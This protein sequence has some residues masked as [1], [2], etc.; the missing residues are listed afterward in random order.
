LNMRGP[1]SLMRFPTAIMTAQERIRENKPK[2]LLHL[3]I[4][5]Y[6]FMATNKSDHIYALLGIAC[7]SG[8]GDLGIVADYKE[9]TTKV[10][11]QVAEAIIKS[12]TNLELLTAVQ[13]NSAAT[14]GQVEESVP[15]LPSWVPNWSISPGTEILARAIPENQFSATKSSTCKA[16]V[17]GNELILSGLIFDEI[18]AVSDIFSPKDSLGVTD[19]FPQVHLRQIGSIA[20][21]GHKL[22]KFF[23]KQQKYVNGEDMGRAANMTRNAGLAG[24][25]A[26]GPINLYGHLFRCS[27]PIYSFLRAIGAPSLF[28]VVGLF[29][30]L[31][32]PFFFGSRS[33]EWRSTTQDRGVW[34]SRRFIRSTRG[35]IGL[36]STNV[37]LGDK[38]ALLEGGAVPFIVRIKE[39]AAVRDHT[40]AELIGEAYVHGI[41]SGNEWDEARCQEI[42]LV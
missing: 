31:P 38:I 26:K 25:P 14:Q 8:P 12:S 11:R 34:T 36:A 37:Q 39:D 41:M 9:K 23:G 7:D 13:P 5:H 35:Y 40:K 15:G 4:D 16:Q 27:Y 33:G 3:L 28:G 2:K 17:S 24:Q 10:Y 6:E 30:M 1:V 29:F 21:M 22:R 18:I 32:V 42:R 19:E 20:E